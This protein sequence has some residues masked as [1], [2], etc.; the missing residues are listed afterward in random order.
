MHK[1]SGK[2]AKLSVFAFNQF[3]KLEHENKD[4]K[5]GTNLNGKQIGNYFKR[6]PPFEYL[7]T[8]RVF[9]NGKY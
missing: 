2:L 8:S 3:T 5:L 6:S 4:N 1:I 7:Q 9:I